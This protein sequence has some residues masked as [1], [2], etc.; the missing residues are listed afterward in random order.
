LSAGTHLVY[1]VSG[2]CS[3]RLNSEDFVIPHG[4]TLKVELTEASQLALVSG[5]AVL[6]SIR[7]AG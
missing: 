7:L 1:A 4:S 5:L 6:G 2:N 3:I